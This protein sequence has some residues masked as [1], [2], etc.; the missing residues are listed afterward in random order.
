M[1]GRKIS[2][3]LN[4][5]TIIKVNGKPIEALSTENKGGEIDASRYF[6]K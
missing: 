1:T 5:H 6:K 4:M 2:N 3:G